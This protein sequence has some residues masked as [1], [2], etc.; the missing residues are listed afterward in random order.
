MTK[1]AGS[2]TADFVKSASEGIGV[3]VGALVGIE[4]LGTAILGPVVGSLLGSLVDY[5]LNKLGEIVFADY[6]GVVAVDQIPLLGRDLYLKTKDGALT[7]TT[8]YR[9]TDLSPDG[10]SNSVYEETWTI[11]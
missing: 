4:I 9:G 7:G 11:G 10:G 8:T 5:L 2:I 1:A 3:G 6:D